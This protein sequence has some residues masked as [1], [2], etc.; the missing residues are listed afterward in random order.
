MGIL[1]QQKVTKEDDIVLDIREHEGMNHYKR[2]HKVLA[3]LHLHSPQKDRPPSSIFLLTLWGVA[4]SGRR[5][6]PTNSPAPFPVCAEA[7]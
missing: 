6:S 4:F 7:A 1:G 5:G 3:V 2:K